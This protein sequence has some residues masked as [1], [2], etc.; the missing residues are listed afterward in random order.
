MNQ[1][2]VKIDTSVCRPSLISN[3]RP[4]RGLSDRV[5]AN[6]LASGVAKSTYANLSNMIR[7]MLWVIVDERTRDFLVS[8][9]DQ[10]LPLL[11]C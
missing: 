5:M 8:N 10:L 3:L 2:D 9:Q 6:V 7:S 11:A 1:S 4:T